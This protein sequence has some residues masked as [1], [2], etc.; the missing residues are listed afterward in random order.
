M[1]MAQVVAVMLQLH[2]RRLQDPTESGIVLVLGCTDWQRDMLRAELRRLIPELAHVVPVSNNAMPGSSAASAGCSCCFQLS[3]AI[4]ARAEDPP[5]YGAGADRES[6]HRRM[7]SLPGRVPPTQT[8]GAQ[9]AATA[10]LRTSLQLQQQRAPS[11]I[12]KQAWQQLQRRLQSGRPVATRRLR[13]APP[14]ALQT[15]Q[16]L[17]GARH[18]KCRWRSAMRFQ[19]RRGLTFTIQGVSR[20]G[21]PSPRRPRPSQSADSCIRY[22]Q[23]LQSNIANGCKPAGRAHS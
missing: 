23:H 17:S 3:R 8:A 10:S 4:S 14:T 20:A 2:I 7:G 15:M 1:C 12:R 9:Q 19:H 21:V 6:V 13:T 5:R 11:L 22:G 18:R 16:Q